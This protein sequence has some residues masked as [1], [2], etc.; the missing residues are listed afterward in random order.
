MEGHLPLFVLVLPACVPTPTQGSRAG[1]QTYPR[2][3]SPLSEPGTGAPAHL[4]VLALRFASWIVWTA[5]HHL[6]DGDHPLYWQRFFLSQLSPTWP[7][8][9]PTKLRVLQ[10]YACDTQ[11][12]I[13]LLFF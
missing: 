1:N 9:G 10:R 11:I 3:G 7:F 5:F 2:G 8:S 12:N 6:M 13:A 4:Y